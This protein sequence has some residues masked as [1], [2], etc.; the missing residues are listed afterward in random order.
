MI[1]LRESLRAKKCPSAEVSAEQEALHSPTA[2]A[3]IKERVARK[4]VVRGLFVS[5]RPS[6]DLNCRAI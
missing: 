1:K 2:L 4:P 3:E 6:L 5:K